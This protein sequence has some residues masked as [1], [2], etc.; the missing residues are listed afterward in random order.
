MSEYLSINEAAELLGVTT[1]SI[2][3][4]IADGTLPAYRVGS[5]MVRI[6]AR[7]IEDKVLKRIPAD[8]QDDNE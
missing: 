1:K 3:R 5:K 8:G 7:D 4:W 2:R 6:R